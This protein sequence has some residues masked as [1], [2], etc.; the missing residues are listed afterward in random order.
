VATPTAKRSYAIAREFKKR[1]RKVFVGGFHPTF[2]IDEC[3][4]YV[5][6]V[7]V[8]EAE[9]SIQEL[10]RDFE[11]GRLKQTYRKCKPCNAADIPMVR[12]EL[13]R[14]P[15]EYFTVN[16]IEATRGCVFKCDFCGV[17]LFHQ[18]TYRKRPVDTVVEEIRRM[19]GRKVLFTDDNLAGDFDYAKELFRRLIPLKKWWMGQMSINCHKDGQLLELA[20]E[21]GCFGVFIGFETINKETI[22]RVR[23]HQ[24]VHHDYKEVVSTL[25]KHGIGVAAGLMFGFDGD[26]K[27]VF[28]DTVRFFR[29]AKVDCIQV[30]PV[31]GFPGTP[32]FERYKREGRLITDDWDKFNIAETTF[33]PTHMTAEEL[34]KGLDEVRRGFYDFP[35]I[36]KRF[37]RAWCY[38]HLIAALVIGYIN[39]GYWRHLRKEIGYPP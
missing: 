14:H 24:N 2:N 19:K 15:E 3:L 13:V 26:T 39:W 34:D 12:P 31:T 38:R 11:K 23:K 25:H 27:D 10:V 35:G 22:D 7:V 30:D 6:A 37:F 5:D 21:S 16:V 4:E 17:R 9:N 18:D 8:G 36:V 1:G 32:L 28:S 33:R 20:A 29:D